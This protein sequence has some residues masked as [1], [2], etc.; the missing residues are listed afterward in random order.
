[1]AASY[2]RSEIVSGLFV[3]VAV[4]AF[5]LLVFRVGGIHPDRW[6]GQAGTPCRVVFQD[7]KTLAVGAKVVVGGRT[8]GSV[9]DIGLVSSGLDS[10]NAATPQSMGIAVD[11]ELTAGNLRV[12]WETAEIELV[13]DGV[14]GRHHLSLHPGRWSAESV[15]ATLGALPQ[16]TKSGQRKVLGPRAGGGGIDGIMASV[17]PVLARIE[18]ILEKFDER[19]MSE[20]NLARLERMFD[21][22]EQTLGNL[23]RAFDGAQV[24]GLRARILDPIAEMIRAAQ[25]TVAD[26]IADGGNRP[27]AWRGL[28]L[29]KRWAVALEEAPAGENARRPSPAACTST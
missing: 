15:P 18:G 2:K 1:M 24:D 27:L 25:Q 23:R 21:Y 16:N 14:L 29:A 5:A 12:D 20:D 19:V 4:V 28:H 17:T 9:T 3:L 11:F 7:V 26:A 8:V 22:V 10:A 13:Q 6:F